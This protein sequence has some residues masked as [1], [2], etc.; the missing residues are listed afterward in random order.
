MFKYNV[1]LKTFLQEDMPT[2]EFYEDLFY[3][4]IKYVGK[5]DVSLHCFF[6]FFFF[7]FVLF[8]FLFLI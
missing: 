4:F 2:P 8:L 7:F 5:T 3:K 1:G 6:F